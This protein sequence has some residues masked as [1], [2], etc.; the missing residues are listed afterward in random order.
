MYHLFYLVLPSMQAV[1]VLVPTVRLCLPEESF[2]PTLLKFWSTELKMWSARGSDNFGLL[3]K[4]LE[5]MGETSIQTS[6]NF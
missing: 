5:P 1:W 6:L 3:P 2:Y 4:I